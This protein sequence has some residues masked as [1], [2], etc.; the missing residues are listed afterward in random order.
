MV[1]ERQLSFVYA[2]LFAASGAFGPWLGW[3]LI[4]AGHAPA[5]VAG[6]LAL[7]PAT[8]VFGGPAW[9]WVADRYRLGT[10]QLTLTTAGAA[11]FGLLLTFPLPSSWVPCAL[12]ALGAMRAGMGSVLDAFTVRS[13][14][15]R[16]ADPSTY[17]QIRRWGSVGYVAGVVAASGLLVLSAAAPLL[18]G[19]CLWAIGAAG[20]ATLP[21][22]PT[23]ARPAVAPAL[24][25]LAQTPGLVW[26]LA[27]FPLYGLGMTAYDVWYAVHIEQLGLAARWTSAAVTC[28][29]VT[30]VVVM[31]RANALFARVSPERLVVGSLLVSGA[32]WALIAAIED[33]I[34]LTLVQ[35]SHGVS[36]GAFWVGAVEWLRRL[37]PVDVRASAQ[38]V[39]PVLGYG[40]GPMLTGITARAVVTDHGTSALFAIGAAAAAAAGFAALAARRHPTVA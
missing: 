5:E 3:V 9:A 8:T 10:R 36:F 7:M 31:G 27:A 29:V 23:A 25:K 20:L 30:E 1:T 11:A 35:L 4:R 2:V 32:R 24:L 40:V 16:G 37:A 14:E 38:M 12:V 28:G 21:R 13:L 17:G 33:P 18:L 15:L 22:V 34:A 39:L 19:A 6:W 26:L